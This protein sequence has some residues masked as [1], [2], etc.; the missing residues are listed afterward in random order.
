MSFQD[1]KTPYDLRFIDF[2]LS[3]YASPVLDLV[4]IL[5]CCCTQETRSK[6]YDQLVHEYYETL[7]KFLKKYG[8]DPDILFPYE[9]LLQQFRKFGMYAAG[10]ALYVI[11]LFS[12]DDSDLDLMYN[13]NLLEER[14]QTNNFYKSML[15]G[16]LKDLIDR[17]YI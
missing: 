1:G 13:S 14:I 4:Y 3:R 5:F 9:A 11:H 8:Y 7:A 10:M 12:I 17:N 6:Y 15:K 2:Q 16:T